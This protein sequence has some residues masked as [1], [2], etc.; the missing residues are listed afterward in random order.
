MS[1]KIFGTNSFIFGGNGFVF[2]IKD[3][4]HYKT[5]QIGNQIWMAETLQLDDGGDGI[6]IIYDCTINGINYGDVYYYTC[7]AATRVA[8]TVDGWHLPTKSEVDELVQYVNNGNYNSTL[9]TKMKSTTGW[10]SNGTDDYGWNAKPLGMIDHGGES[11]GNESTMWQ[12]NN[13]R[14]YMT[15]SNSTNNST[16]SDYYQYPIR[17]IKD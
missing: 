14:W 2:G 1:D 16:E 4:F 11:L 17:L 15:N 6:Y 13:Y 9:C 8:Q 10:G 7:A 12:T 5:V 3:S